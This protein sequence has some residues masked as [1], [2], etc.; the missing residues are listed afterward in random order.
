[1][2]FISVLHFS[3]IRPQIY[4]SYIRGLVSVV[5]AETTKITQTPLEWSLLR[6]NVNHSK[7]WAG[8]GA[9]RTFGS[10]TT[11]HALRHARHHLHVPT[12]PVLLSPPLLPGA[13][14]I[15]RIQA[16]TASIPRYSSYCSPGAV[17]VM[18]AGS[19]NW[20]KTDICTWGSSGFPWLEGKSKRN[21]E[22]P[23]QCCP[24]NQE[25]WLVA[26]V[27]ENV[28]AKVFSRVKTFNPEEV[29]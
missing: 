29:G 19:Q 27:S 25:W 10:K 12:P 2:S 9:D 20:R 18:P 11:H 24:V 3:L 5:F 17:A 4:N 8:M 21:I 14:A 22:S 13:A 16:V 23:A 28:A 6:G 1:M 26:P 15:S 7:L